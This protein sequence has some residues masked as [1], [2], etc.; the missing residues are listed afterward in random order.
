MGKIKKV[1][2]C[3]KCNAYLTKGADEPAPL[4]CGRAMT[5]IDEFSEDEIFEEKQPS[6]GILFRNW[7]GLLCH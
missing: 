5:E 6:G 4:C 7:G 3:K 1:Y 2:T